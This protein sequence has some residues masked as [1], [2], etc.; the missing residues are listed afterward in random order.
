MELRSMFLN[1]IVEYENLRYVDTCNDVGKVFK[2]IRIKFNYSSCTL[3][4]FVNLIKFYN[5]IKLINNRITLEYFDEEIF[6]CNVDELKE[7][8]IEFT[9][10]IENED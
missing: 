5:F 8:I 3:D 6:T 9:K 1:N 10:K 7:K 4:S 2:K